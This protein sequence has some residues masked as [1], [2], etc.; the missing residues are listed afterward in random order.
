MTQSPPNFFS[1]LA[2]A[3]FNL[4]VPFIVANKSVELAL[5]YT[6]STKISV[7]CVHSNLKIMS[8]CVLIMYIYKSNGR[9]QQNGMF[10][11]NRTS[12]VSF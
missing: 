10:R 11:V 7:L 9:T 6:F 1:L 3:C 2:D 4:C 12:V 8:N 5:L